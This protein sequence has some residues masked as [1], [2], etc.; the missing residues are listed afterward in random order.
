MNFYSNKTNTELQN[1]I[2]PSGERQKDKYNLCKECCKYK[3]D[4]LQ[5][6]KVLSGVDNISD[7]IHIFTIQLTDKTDKP[8]YYNEFYCNLNE[9]SI[10]YNKFALI[11]YVGMLGYAFSIIEETCIE[12]ILCKYNK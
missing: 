11:Y 7:W 3:T 4:D 2:L 12:E 6:V 9:N 5:L 8:S 1:E 10:H